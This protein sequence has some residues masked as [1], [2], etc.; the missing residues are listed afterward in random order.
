MIEYH[1]YMNFKD[2][3]KSIITMIFVEVDI[4]LPKPILEIVGI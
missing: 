3:N 2:E 1:I 4:F